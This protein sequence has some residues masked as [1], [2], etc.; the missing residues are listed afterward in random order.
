VT[1]MSVGVKGEYQTVNATEI[2]GIST[3]PDS[4]NSYVLG[5]PD[6]MDELAAKLIKRLCRK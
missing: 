5:T 4:D 1:M 2:D 6:L 3:D